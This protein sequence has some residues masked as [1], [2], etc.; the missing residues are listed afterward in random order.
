MGGGRTG[1]RAGRR[2]EGLRVLVVEDFADARETVRIVLQREGAVVTEAAS[3]AEA[4]AFLQAGPF[5]II[6][7]DIGMPEEDGLSMIQRIR[8][9]PGQ[10][11]RTPAIALTAWGMD[12]DRERALAA[13]YQAYIVKPTDPGTLATAI[14]RLARPVAG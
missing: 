3:A 9:L 14:A 8:G 1:D 6:V 12:E 7:G 4:L 10:A 2:L 13:G 11:G 5:D